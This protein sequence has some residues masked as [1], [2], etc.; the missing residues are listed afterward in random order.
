MTQAARDVLQPH[1]QRSSPTMPTPC[2]ST[3]AN[4]NTFSDALARNS[5][6]STASSP[7]SSA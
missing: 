2:K 5:D 4:L 6:R 1:R 3:I 7:D